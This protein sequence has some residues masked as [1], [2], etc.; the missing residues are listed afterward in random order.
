MGLYLEEGVVPQGVDVPVEAESKQRRKQSAHQHPE[1]QVVP[2]RKA[3]SKNTAGVT[4][5]RL[6]SV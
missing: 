5:N 6:W 2:Q 3:F 4:K 1:A